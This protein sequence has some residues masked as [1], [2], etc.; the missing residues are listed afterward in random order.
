MQV[1]I[2]LRRVLSRTLVHF[3]WCKEI[4][5]TLDFK[6][7]F[8]TKTACYV[9]LHTFWVLLF[10]LKIDNINFPVFHFYNFQFIN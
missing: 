2:V 1:R 9:T 3:T 5:Y 4:N 8:C 6:E 10:L 7:F